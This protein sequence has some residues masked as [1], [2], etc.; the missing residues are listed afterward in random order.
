MR[1]VRG[2]TKGLECAVALTWSGLRKNNMWPRPPGPPERPRWGT[3]QD[4]HP[5]A[6]G[7]DPLPPRV[8]HTHSVHW[9]TDFELGDQLQ[10][11]GN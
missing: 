8:L 4:P 2:S 3:L 9:D 10:R 11:C 7:S 1:P 6:Q 5:Q